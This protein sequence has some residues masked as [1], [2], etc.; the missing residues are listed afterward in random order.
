M[1]AGVGVRQVDVCLCLC[2]EDGQVDEIGEDDSVAD[3]AL[4]DIVV[5]AKAAPSSTA[6][7]RTA[8][9]RARFRTDNTAAASPGARRP[10]RP[11]GGGERRSP[12]GRS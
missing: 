6:E 10:S 12:A 2:P 3:L 1:R 9:S 8:C 11:G 7:Q 4:Y 5:A